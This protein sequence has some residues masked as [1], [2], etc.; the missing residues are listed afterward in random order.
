MAVGE[1]DKDEYPLGARPGERPSHGRLGPVP[2]RSR[3]CAAAGIIPLGGFATDGEPRTCQR[4]GVSRK[5]TTVQWTVIPVNARARR[6]WACTQAQQRQRSAA[7]ERSKAFF[8]IL[9]AAEAPV[10]QYFTPHSVCI[11][12]CLSLFPP[13]SF[14]PSVRGRHFLRSRVP[15]SLESPGLAGAVIHWIAALSPARPCATPATSKKLR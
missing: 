1:P 8:S 6:A 2:N 11:L 5:Q 15:A 13:R 4:S 9:L 3:E 12:R 10:A 14:H 7:A